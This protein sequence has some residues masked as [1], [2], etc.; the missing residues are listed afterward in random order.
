MIYAL[1]TILIILIILVYQNLNRKIQILEQKISDLSKDKAKIKKQEQAFTETIR[2]EALPNNGNEVE[3]KTIPETIQDN[4]EP[5]NDRL[6]PVFD[7]IKQNVLTIIGI[8]TLVLG[9]G[10][11]VKYAIDKN[12]IGESARMG[13]GFLAGSLLIITAHFIRK[14]YTVFSSIIMGGGIAVFYFTTTIAFREYHLFTQNTAFAI[15]CAITLLS[16]FLSYRYNSETLIIFSLFGGFLAPLMI[17]TGQSNYIFLFTYLSL[18]NIGM[19]I[20]VY[21][22]NWKS[23]GW[24]AFIFTAI[25]LYFWTIEKTDLTSIIFY[26]IT[27]IIFYAF[28][29]YNYFKT[30]LLSKLDILML[31]LINFSSIIGSVYIFSILKYE[32]LSVFPL[33]FALI[34]IFFAF[35]EYLD[36]K[37]ERN[38]S[39]FAGI[40]IGLLT[41][42]VALQFKTHLIT[43]VWAIEASLLLYIWKKTGHNIFK[44][45][46]YLLFPLVILSQMMTWTEYINN[47][48][49][50]T[51]IFNPVFLTSLL[52]IASCFFN[53]I[54]LKK[55]SKE[56]SDAEFFQNAFKVL[57]FGVI[58]FSILFELIYQ[59]SSQHFV[60]IITYS[61]LYSIILTTLLLILNK[62]LSISEDLEDLLIYGL[63][64]LFI[65]HI[66][67]SQIV[68]AVITKEIGLSF[69]W[70]HLIYLAPLL[71]LIVKLIPRSEFLKQK[72]GYLLISITCILSVSFELYRIYIF[73]NGTTYQ[74]I[75]QL[76]EHFSIL[77]LPIIWAV[78][79]CG[80][81]FAGLKKNIPE[82]NKIGFGLL[83]IT[84]LKLYLYDVWQMDNVSRII[85][86]IILG[87]ILLL[88][89]FM[90]QK[91]KNMLKNLVDKNE[92]STDDNI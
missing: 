88:S 89:S 61:F 32:P 35:R 78:L 66:T 31:V 82:L 68:D 23:V 81:I 37:F 59:L 22:K 42:A 18:L 39:V 76:Q 64:F 11:F 47:K 80:S 15:T 63:L 41:L 87:I 77:Y 43:S 34:N 13:I 2:S 12:W 5:E 3:Q 79:S 60:V 10:Y 84:I 74:N 55:E 67:N 33:S 36:K 53:L 4:S 20:T 17:S 85:A 26:I 9:I 90:F 8:F 71:Y 86:F 83:G 27:Y 56:K 29:L 50:L 16:I 19:L 14:N 75:F 25:Y 48:K 69:Y 91:F 7:F 28:A 92:N 73:L 24:I 30:K 52:V 40:G 44:I 21:L 62:R 72:A 6:A 46:F 51:L 54:L 65:A 38:Y 57:C 1:I 45:F 70:I 58:Y 49:H